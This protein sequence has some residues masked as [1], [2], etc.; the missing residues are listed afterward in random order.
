MEG[1]RTV[2][3]IY[4]ILQISHARR[5]ANPDAP[6][7][8]AKLMAAY[9]EK[10]TTLFWVSENYL[11]HGFAWYKFYTLCKEYNKVMSDEMKNLQASAVLLAALC[12]PQVPTGTGVG[13][14]SMNQKSKQ[15]QQNNSHGIRSTMEDDI[16]K[17][18]M[19]RMATL[20]GFHTRNPTREALL[21]EIRSK[22]ILEQVPQYLR[23][24]Y[25]LL[26]E[27]SDPLIMVGQARP[28]LE[29]LKN[30][31]R[32][33]HME[34]S[35]FE[36]TK[37]DPAGY[38]ESTTS[39]GR[40]VKPLTAVLLQKL[41]VNLAASYHTVSLDHLKK[42]TSG[43][44]AFDLT[45]EQVEKAIVQFTLQATKSGTALSV[46]I[47]HRA[48]CL[49]FGEANLESELMRSQLTVLYKQ[50]MKVSRI[51][52][53]PDASI[54]KARLETR[55]QRLLMIRSALPAEHR[56]ILDRKNYIEECKEK[57]ERM[58]QEKI[59]DELRTKAEEELARK[60]EEE[61][62]IAREQKMREQE[63]QK[64]IQMELENQ[65]KKRFLVSMGKYKEGITEEQIAKIDTEALQKEH[66]EKL[67]KE[68]EEAERK[69]KEAAKKLDYLV[70]AIRIEELPLIKKQ[71]EEKT[72]MDR[73]EYEQE[74]KAK[75]EQAKIQWE[76]DVKDKS[77]LEKH[78]VFEHF[79]TFEEY[80][81]KGRRMKHEQLCREADENALVEAEKAKLRR[82]RRRKDE[83]AK[84]IADEIKRKQ[85]EEEERIRKEEEA[86]K[87]KAAEEAKRIQQ[88][89]DAAEAA[90]AAARAAE[91]ES[92]SAAPVTATPTA[93]SSTTTPAP[94]SLASLS[95]SSGGGTGGKYVPPSLRG[96][97]GSSGGG[98]GD[99]GGSRG[100]YNNSRPGSRFGS[101][102]GGP[103]GVGSSSGGGGSYPGGGRYEGRRTTE[104]SSSAG[105]GGGGSGGGERPRF[106]NSSVGRGGGVGGSDENKRSNEQQPRENS[107]WN[108]K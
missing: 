15:Q 88:E 29:Q 95:S 59:K 36:E 58:A 42:L 51:L 99:R 94:R 90:A 41:I 33:V 70:R 44:E 72:N 16:V 96:A 87:K 84:R 13:D 57:A 45:F 79:G 46:R 64:R 69:L 3:D 9:Y 101:G 7:P 71:Y 60:L 31:D 35:N 18:K 2:E 78:S 62:R 68:K 22:N 63:K 66:Q 67:I 28:L 73:E 54:N 82:A 107:R 4:N 40:Y 108:N 32:Q 38:D 98:D 74:V 104:S 56:S 103:G 24:L 52:E 21:T 106:I 26:E 83:E 85:K 48:N 1:F 12:I 97:A 100:A 30:Q 75:A 11:F 92:S 80:I 65:E 14:A 91:E 23:D 86:I 17:Q 6:A 27:T 55:M 102:G 93:A 10:L 49:R 8:K 19:A 53:V 37:E 34:S 105:G 47:D 89:K 50:L 5:K 77:L 43:L 20:L 76:A 39:L 25:F 81:M 61:K